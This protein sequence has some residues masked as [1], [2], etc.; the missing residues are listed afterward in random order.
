MTPSTLPAK[1]RSQRKPAGG[2]SLAA[3]FIMHRFKAGE[4]VTHLETFE[5]SADSEGMTHYAHYFESYAEALLDY[6][7]RCSAANLDFAYEFS[8][9]H[10]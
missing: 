6:E 10:D 5:N 9:D 3:G 2:G 8:D 1:I 7:A 4:W